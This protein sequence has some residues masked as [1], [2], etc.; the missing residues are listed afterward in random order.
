[1]SRCVL[2]DLDGT[3]VDTAPDMTDA[4]DRLRRERDLPALPPGA[5]RPYV[6]RG[7]VGLVRFGFPDIDDSGAIEELRQRFLA[8]YAERLCVASAPFEG[9]EALLERVEAAARPWGIVTNKPA[10]L[11]E[12]LL[13]ALG[14]LERSAC[15]VCG[16][17]LA[18]RKPDPDPLLHAAEL[19]A[20]PPARCVY[21]GD[22]RRDMLAGRAAGMACLAAGWGY[23]PP[24][25]P[26]DGWGADEILLS[27]QA[28]DEWL[29]SARWLDADHH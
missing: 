8:L 14:L 13:A 24:D 21:V 26:I 3:L 4:L 20:L 16:D 19:L 11:A 18:R 10:W 2:F 27:P 28:L 9:V 23:I 1:M 7:A 22:D 12:P 15:L 6:S 29:T 17:T 5:A 25:E